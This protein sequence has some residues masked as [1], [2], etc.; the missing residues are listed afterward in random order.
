MDFCRR[1][2]LPIEPPAESTLCLFVA[3]LAH[4]RVSPQSIRTYMAA[5]RHLYISMGCSD[6]FGRHHL[7]RLHYVLNGV[8]RSTANSSGPARRRLPI[9][10]VVLQILLR[11][12]SQSP[13]VV[14]AKMLWAACCL[15]F[16][17]F[18][19]AGE[20]TYNPKPG[21]QFPPMLTARDVAVDSRS[22][23]SW[24]SVC[25]RRCKTDQFGQG[26]RLII[27]RSFRQICPVAAMLDYLAT[28]PAVSGPLFVFHNGTPLSRESLIR[29]VRNALGAAGVDPSA[30]SGHSFRIGAAT[31]AA[32][33]GIPEA[34]IK[35]L[36]RWESSAYL[37]YIRTPREQLIPVSARLVETLYRV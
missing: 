21:E 7:P 16:F 6:T 23:P 32:S 30:Y 15:G 12:W 24:M 31:A 18:L 22:A 25:I 1:Y 5:V 28:R 20:F 9:T 37:R 13:R 34:T 35:L 3:F 26:F 4:Q 33:I 27:G 14:D 36:G 17:G 10:P 11:V 19:R 2:N 8:R 29:E